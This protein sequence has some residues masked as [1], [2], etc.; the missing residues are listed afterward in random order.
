MAS[1]QLF[2]L[3]VPETADQFASL[4]GI[5]SSPTPEAHTSIKGMVNYLQGILGGVRSGSISLYNGAVQNT[6]VLTVSAGGSANDETMVLCGV[7]FTAKTSGATGNEFNISATAATQAANMVAAFNASADLT[8]IVTASNVLGVIT[9][10][11]T[12]PGKFGNAL[13][14]TES[15]ANVAVT[16]SFATSAA[17][18]NGTIYS[19]DLS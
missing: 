8:G 13:V 4:M 11:A 7:T 2:V 19:F 9:I 6:A 12:L 10:T 15:L 14:V 16:T 1:K 18:S 5:Q 3:T 17:G